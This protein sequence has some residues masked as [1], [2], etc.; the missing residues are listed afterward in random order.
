MLEFKREASDQW[1]NIS[2]PA[3]N[4]TQELTWIQLSMV[5]TAPSPDFTT[6]FIQNLNHQTTAGFRA[7][8]I[9][10]ITNDTFVA[11]TEAYTPYLLPD[12]VSAISSTQIVVLTPLAFGNISSWVC[13]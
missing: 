12:A 11:F 1:R 3:F 7:D 10:L 13:S 8:Q 5:A 2:L 4:E 9:Q 6:A